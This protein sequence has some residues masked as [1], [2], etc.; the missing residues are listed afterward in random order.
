MERDVEFAIGSKR[1]EPVFAAARVVPGH[2]WVPAIGMDD[3]EIAGVE[4]LP[5]K[6]PTEKVVCI[7]RRTR[8]P[9]EHIPSPRGRERRT[10]DEN[11]LT[12][13]LAGQVESVFGY[14]FI[15]TNL[16]TRT[17]EKLAEVEWWY[18]HRTDIEA[19]NSGAK[20]GGSLRHLPSKYHAI[21]SVWM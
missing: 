6:W 21:N 14:S 8:I 17:E 1:T 12:L 10:I 19:L 11:Q 7:A 3:T 13:A 16:D 20:Q 4:Y 9:V 2:A 18:R 5:G 15:L